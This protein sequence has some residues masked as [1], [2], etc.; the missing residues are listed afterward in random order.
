MPF[1]LSAG[2]VTGGASGSAVFTASRP[3]SVRGSATFSALQ[4]QPVA[5]SATFTAYP[6][7][8]ALTSGLI[9]AASTVTLTGL[10]GDVLAWTY[11]HGGLY[12][13]L[14]VTVTGL[15]GLD[16]P[17]A[18]LEVISKID[19]TEYARLPGRVFS[20][21]GQEPQ[22]DEGANRTTFRFRNDFD[23]ALRGVKL[24]ELLSWRL[25]PPKPGCMPARRTASI[26]SVVHGVMR[27]HVDAHFTLSPDPLA[28]ASWEESRREYSTAGKTPQQVWDD[29]YGALGMVLHVRPRGVGIRLVGCWPNPHGA[30]AGAALS[31][32]L[33]LTRTPQRE[34]RQT[35]AR[36]TLRGA[37]HVTDLTPQKLLEWVGGDPAAQEIAR[38][39]LPE[40]E[41]IDPLTGSGTARTQRGWRK[42]IGQL[43]SEV[44]VTTDDVTVTETV[45]GTLQVREFRGVATGY[46]HTQ[47]T[48]DPLCPSRPLRKV[49]RTR[50]W[51]YA[52]DTELGSF[53]TAGPGLY[54]NLT[55]G[56]LT[57]DELTDTAY[58]YS[59]Q[60]HQLT[61]TESSTALASVQQEGAELPPG[62]RGPVQ[63]REYV[64]TVKRT[65]WQATG[66]G[67]WQRITLVSRQKLV[68]L[69]DLDSG[70]AIRT[71][72]VTSTLPLPTE[73]TDQAP[74]SFECETCPKEVRDP[75]GVVLSA[76]D[77]GFGDA[78]EV[79]LDFVEPGG[80]QA[81]AG[82]MLTN[83]WHRISTR[84]SLR[85][86]VPYFPGSWVNGALVQE[87]RLSQ[88]EGDSRVTTE[89]RTAALD[90]TL[91]SPTQAGV[92]D[93][94]LPLDEGR[95][96]MLAGRPGGARVRLVKGWDA[97]AGQPKTEDDAFVA[98]RTGFPPRPGEEIDWT[99]YA[100]R[101]EARSAR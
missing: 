81:I 2:A 100:G 66:A 77:A 15:H 32:D 8:A 1:I 30:Q 11:N 92:Y 44:Q 60:G 59:P 57:A 39:V 4:A 68:P 94:D 23:Q 35:P 62:E 73:V 25:E 28:G 7:L 46:T 40:G 55:V 74:P 9:D 63:G 70:D 18:F 3:A 79:T 96:I 22:T 52:L 56:D 49:T 76:G 80:L 34:Q 67:R 98:F 16:T 87:L 99:R 101:L 27:D 51:A 84:F 65:S 38:E 83:D 41:Y 6:A 95:A 64:R 61:E 21:L 31:P 69:Y 37:D 20:H 50:S 19:G 10:P 29:T 71:Q 75:T 88:A 5:G 48:L 26:S 47:I 36:L 14:D 17:I 33:I 86:A 43:V 54:W 90:T 91:L 24:P 42:T 12:E 97:Q 72:L 78:R 93:L 53:S 85:V 82:Q 58:T 13:E 89:L 45:D